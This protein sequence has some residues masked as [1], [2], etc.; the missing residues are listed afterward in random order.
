MKSYPNQVIVLGSGITA[1][2]T[3]DELISLGIK[4]TVIDIGK[5]IPSEGLSKKKSIICG[6]SWYG[7]YGGYSIFD[8]NKPFKINSKRVCSSHQYGGFGSLWT[9]SFFLPNKE[10]LSVSDELFDDIIFYAKQFQ[11]KFT[12]LSNNSLFKKKDEINNN[13]TILTKSRIAVNPN[14]Y[15]LNTLDGT[16]PS[17]YSQ[18]G[19]IFSPAA[20]IKSYIERNL[21][22]YIG[23]S[24]VVSI[25]KPDI[26]KIQ[27]VRY[28]KLESVEYEKLF[29]CC[30]C[31]NSLYLASDHIRVKKDFKLNIAPSIIFPLISF[32]KRN[33]LTVIPSQNYNAPSNFLIIKNINGI[34]DSIYCQIGYLN[35]EIL[36]KVKIPKILKNFIL[37]FRDYIFIAQLRLSSR[38]SYP[39]KVKIKPFKDCFNPGEI[40]L[41]EPK[42]K[43]KKSILLKAFLEVSFIFK[44]RGMFT[45]PLFISLYALLTKSRV[46]GWHMGANL[47]DFDSYELIENVYFVDSVS[48]GH[49]PATTIVPVLYGRSRSL[50]KYS[51][52]K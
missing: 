16:A 21:I 5:I 44:K 3:I 35:F 48:L 25:Q 43:I 9:G 38:N 34:K 13:N 20:I 30:G 42:K 31:I 19:P 47:N 52:N 26:K 45:H 7:N 36:N 24:Y 50:V 6:K 37:L 46:C 33:K 15:K 4:P 40:E 17:S 8:D 14:E 1:L 27:I 22:K 2:G 12:K 10:D 18:F 11:D 23:D 51:L 41:K 49:V 29:V 32:K 39:Y 28:G